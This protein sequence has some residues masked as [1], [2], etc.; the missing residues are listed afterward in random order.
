MKNVTG[1]HVMVAAVAG[2]AIGY[3]FGKKK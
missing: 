1:S 2:L 3:W